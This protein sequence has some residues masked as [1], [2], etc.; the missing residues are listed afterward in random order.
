E[1]AF[2]RTPRNLPTADEADTRRTPIGSILTSS[3]GLRCPRIFPPCPA[4]FFALESPHPLRRFGRA[5]R[6]RPEGTRS[7]VSRETRETPSLRVTAE[8]SVDRCASGAKH[9]TRRFHVKHIVP[10]PIG[11]RGDPLKDRCSREPARIG[12]HSEWRAS[13]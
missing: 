8:A 6:T 3:F 1:A 5:V 7:G 4:R 11:V 2:S 9:A 12:S 13:A 10:T